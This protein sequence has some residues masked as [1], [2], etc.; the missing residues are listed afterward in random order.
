MKHIEVENDHHH[1]REGL[2]SINKCAISLKKA[3]CFHH[4]PIE[5]PVKSH[6]KG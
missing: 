2:R 3:F 1:M 6:R 5:F 4:F